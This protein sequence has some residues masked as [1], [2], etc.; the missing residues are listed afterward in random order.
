LE[1][2]KKIHIIEKEGGAILPPEGFGNKFVE[3][4][5]VGL[6]FST[7]VDVFSV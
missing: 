5:K 2:T 7:N 6:A 4:S 3:R 1:L